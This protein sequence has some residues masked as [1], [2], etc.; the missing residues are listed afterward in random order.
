[1][2]TTFFN[3]LS[4]I[5]PMVDKQ[6]LLVACS[7]GLDSVVLV[8]LCRENNLEFGIAHC[9][10]SLRGKESDEDEQFVSQ[11]A[12]QLEVPFYVET[13]NTKKV[14]EELGI[15]TQMAARDLRYTWFEEIR[16][17]FK[18]DW[19]LT[20]H[21]LDDDLETF[22]INLSRSTGLKGLTGIPEVQGKVLRPMLCFGR[23][24]ILN[25]A[26]K[27]HC[28]WR[29]DSSNASI[30][31]LRN[32]FRHDLLPYYKKI[33]SHWK[34]SFLSTSKYLQGS[35]ALI[36]DYLTLVTHLVFEERELGVA[37]NI[38]KLR[39]LSH[40]ETLLYELLKPYGFTAWDD[41]NKMLDA[42]SGKQI[43]SGTHR[44]I[45][46]RDVLLLTEL[47][48]KSQSFV[49][50]ITKNETQIADPLQMSFIPTD[51]MGY[52]DNNTIYV[53]SDKL[54]YP[55]TLRKW[56]KGDVFQPFGLKGNKKLSKY[57]KDEKLSL[58]AKEAT[59]VLLSSDQIVW[60]VGMRMDDRFKITPNTK[61]ILKI[62]LKN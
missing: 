61:S 42:Q 18:Y 13:F 36:E 34:E 4:S 50:I 56:E 5:A 32:E 39:A 6:R 12:E 20:A 25:F 58:A 9:N 14:A 57:F 53:D 22:F 3:Q 40:H 29:E 8:R 31:Y 19:I 46:D 55:L 33:V 26:K 47:S 30:D 44:L 62:A 27:E 48:R 16:V 10:F 37:L 60:V 43:L 17:D 51:E 45:K 28:Y 1:M 2:K 21:H 15:S 52:I 41:I 24:E 11:L 49:K 7:G 59:W 38:E 23:D 54:K 35:Q